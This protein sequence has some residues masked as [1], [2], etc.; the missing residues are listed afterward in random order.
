[1]THRAA[2][3]SIRVRQPDFSGTEA[4]GPAASTHQVRLRRRPLG[5][6]AMYDLDLNR[7]TVDQETAGE[8]LLRQAR[9][10]WFGGSFFRCSTL[11]FPLLSCSVGP[12]AQRRRRDSNPRD[13]CAPNGF[14]DRRLQPL[15]H[16]SER[17]VP[18]GRASPQRNS[19][20]GL[21]A[22]S[23]YRIDEQG[24]RDRRRGGWGAHA[25]DIAKHD[26]RLLA[27]QDTARSPLS[28]RHTDTLAIGPP[29]WIEPV[30]IQRLDRGRTT[31]IYR[32]V[33]LSQNAYESERTHDCSTSE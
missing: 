13:A 30:I 22:P 7:R 17:H 6:Q 29:L 2:S 19:A 21:P 33:P 14:Q 20:L 4:A 9:P 18:A 25:T 3:F 1:M 23:S 11:Y 31:C 8:R 27:K 32:H 5:I 15:G 24:K 10:P 26:A 28:G 16:A 12:S